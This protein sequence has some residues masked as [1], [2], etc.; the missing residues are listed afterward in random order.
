MATVLLGFYVSTILFYFLANLTDYEQ[1]I[2][3]GYPAGQE[4]QV[5]FWTRKRINPKVIS[6]TSDKV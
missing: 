5:N 3:H 4:Y 2:N 1:T 6:H